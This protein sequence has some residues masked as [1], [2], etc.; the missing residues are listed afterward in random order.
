MS[1]DSMN[2]IYGKP[3]LRQEPSDLWNQGGGGGAVFVDSV[4]DDVAT[5]L[6][7]EHP[8][9]IPASELPANAREGDWVLDGR[10]VPPPKQKN[11]IYED[12]GG[13]FGL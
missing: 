7:G 2:A 3:R 10:I 8:M 5:V 1:T 11:P 4:E 12:D 6:A 13:D 9:T